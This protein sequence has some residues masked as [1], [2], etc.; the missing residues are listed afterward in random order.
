MKWTLS[1]PVDEQK[2]N[3]LCG[4][5]NISFPLASILVRRGVSDFDG[6][7]AY[8]RPTLDMLHDP[9]LM[10][11]MNR[12]VTR[13][14]DAVFN[15][16]RVLIYG[17]YDVDGTTSVSLLYLF[18]KNHLDTI[19]YYIPD[20][21]TE[22]YG[23]SKKGIAYA[24]DNGFSLIIT[25][26]CGIR[27]VDMCDLAESYD[28]DVIICDHH[29]PGAELPRAHA[30]LD[31][32]Q[33]NCD[34]PYKELSGCGVG[35]KLLQ[36]FC[37]QQTIPLENL[38]AY[39]DLL[40]ISIGA[41]IVP[42][43]GENRVLAYYGLKKINESPMTSVR[44][45]IELAGLKGELTITNVVFGI[46]PRINA[47]GRI[48]HAKGAVKLL[49]SANKDHLDE[50][51]IAMEQRNRERKNYDS[52]ITTEALEMIEESDD[53][54]NSNA[55]VLFK[56]DW[57]KGVIGIVASR[58]I[59]KY[60][61]PTIILTEDKGLLTGSAR[62]IDG[63]NV[64]SAIE[65]CED[66]LE[67]FG[68]H[69]Y[70]AGLSLKKENFDAFKFKF[71]GVVGDTLPEE[72]KVPKIAIDEALNFDDINEKFVDVLGQMAPFGPGNMTPIFLSEHVYVVDPPRL[73][74]EK[75]L[76]ATLF[77]KDNSSS[78][79]AIGFNLGELST[80]MQIGNTFSIVYTVEMNHFRGKSTIQLNI[81]DVKPT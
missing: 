55:T 20:R 65:H 70:A 12:A 39:M 31:P 61:R 57:H 29:L 47:M 52:A 34:Y 50:L 17:D 64:H 46:A 66:L 22:G 77:Q 69:K 28:I 67:K 80:H 6:A 23:V 51:S 33:L 24:R 14:T 73:L 3:T 32:K 16:E 53:S 54:L 38:F 15:Q 72:L 4:L 42:I 7:K 71:D 26:D 19:E 56:E 79:D 49:T 40:S 41:D 10:K 45:L 59:E 58:C 44:S 8:F 30:I 35:F 5:I 1:S 68:G 43:T 18:L 63:Y 48:S 37:I 74:K 2:V 36:A 60:Y 75:H 62:S 27:A 76:K 21:Y 13:L 81:R 78:Y 25:L 9:F 11:D